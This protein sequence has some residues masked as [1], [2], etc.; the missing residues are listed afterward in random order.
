MT[1]ADALFEKTRVMLV[2]QDEMNSRVDAD[3]RER[4]REWN[5]AIWIECAE[6]MDHYGG[7]KWWKHTTPDLEQAML[8][9]VDI[10]HFGLSLR[11]EAAGDF[12]AA[13]HAIVDEWQ[14]SDADGDF[15]AEVERLA[16]AALVE[17]RF[18][19]DAVA[20]LVTLCGHDLDQLY[21][22]YVAKNVLNFF[23]QN[24][25]YRT[26]E[27]IKTWHGREDNAVLAELLGRLDSD[28]PRFREAVYDALEAAY[29]EVVRTA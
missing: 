24:H 19:V 29:A 8:E 20:R 25:G 23:R 5:R 17:R 15:L 10:W 7:W 26:G 22:A 1:A 28:D 6:L 14:A 2:M 18:A 21:R 9:I 27:Y 16:G 12:D 3:W 4:A 13:A 11:L